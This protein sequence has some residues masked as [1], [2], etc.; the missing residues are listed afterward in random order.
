MLSSTLAQQIAGETT[1]A[2]GYNVIITDTEGMVIGSGDTSRVGSFH[3][4]S[5]EVMRTR[6]SAWHNPEE[7]R[8][9]RGVRPGI[10]LP[11]V[12]GDEAVGTVGITGSPRQVRRFG[13]VVRRQTEILLEESA[14]VRSRLMRERALEDLVNEVAAFDPELVEPELVVSSAAELGFRLLLP[15]CVLLFDVDG[16]AAGP[17][18][19]RVLR[20]VF[21]QHEDIV[22]RRSAG[23]CAILAPVD[24]RRVRN[25]ESEARRAIRMAREALN[26]RLRVAIS[27]PADTVEKLRDCCSD[28]AEALWLGA[29][30]QPADSVL[31]VADLRAQQALAAIG[32][33]VRGRLV[34][35]ELGG[36]RSA[37]DWLQLRATVVLWCESGFNQVAAAKALNIHRNTLLYRLDKI[38]RLVG[39]SWRDHRAMLSLYIA[40]LADQL[41]P[42][43]TMV[44]PSNGRRPGW[45]TVGRQHTSDSL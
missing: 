44:A 12:I 31:R 27:P 43:E 40:C 32:H 29:R 23:R 45:A 1:E 6:E 25:L 8:A 28:A 22:A 14:L 4:A 13:L 3:E 35:Q 7:A 15:R 41:G 19:L 9:L 36:L 2:I 34:E 20:A 42:P 11:L 18:L 24:T 37:A 39:R 33:R 30:V 16:A 38:E 26:L 17:E 10:T 5:I 21:H